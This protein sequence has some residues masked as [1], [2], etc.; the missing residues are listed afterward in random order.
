MKKQKNIALIM[1][2]V[3]AILVVL[4]IVRVSL[5]QKNND[6]IIPEETIK[7]S[8]IEVTATPTPI[9]ENSTSQSNN[10]VVDYSALTNIEI[11]LEQIQLRMYLNDVENLLGKPISVEEKYYE[12]ISGYIVKYEYEFGNIRLYRLINDDVKDSYVKGV[13]V[14]ETNEPVHWDIKIGDSI[15][16]VFEKIGLSFDNVETKSTI[17]YDGEKAIGMIDYTNSSKEE[18]DIMRI[19]YGD[20]DDYNHFMIEFENSRV[21]IL[22][23]AVPQ[24]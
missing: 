9:V 24:Y 6:L 15:E 4:L 1:T 8:F 13:Y 21:L 12:G 22:G 11:T 17:L 23:I 20:D 3:L 7:T 16:D 2:I 18:V 10:I 19:C 14:Y 5:K